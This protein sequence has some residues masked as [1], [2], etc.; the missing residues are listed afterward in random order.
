MSLLRRLADRPRHVPASRHAGG[1]ALAVMLV[2]AQAGCSL[3][4]EGVPP[5]ANRIFYPASAVVDPSG[6]WLFVASSNSDLRYN[7]G[8]LVAVDLTAAR[9]DRAASWQECPAAGYIRRAPGDPPCCLDFLDRTILNCDEQRYITDDMTVR[10]GSFAATMVW[11]DTCP[12]P[13]C[14]QGRLLIGVRGDGSITWIDADVRDGSDGSPP[15]V[16]LRCNDTVGHF[17]E[18]DSAHKVI[19]NDPDHDLPNPIRL[20]DEP[21]ALAVDSS[22]G[23]LYVGHLRGDAISIFD[24]ALN[25]TLATGPRFIAPF[26]NIF[27]LDGNGNAGVTSLNIHQLSG[28]PGELFA[29]SRYVPRVSAFAPTNA[30][31][32]PDPGAARNVA[33]LST[34]IGFDTT[35]V[36]SE[37]RGI[38]F[39]AGN[40]RAYALQRVPPALV[41][42]DVVDDPVRGIVTTATEV[43]EMCSSPTF[44]YQQDLT[45]TG[46]GGTRL[47]VNCFDDNRIYVVD[48]SVPRLIA[49]IDVGQGP[50]GLAFDKA[51]PNLAYV[52]GFGANDLSVLDLT[53]YRVVQRIGFPSKQPR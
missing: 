8:T 4:Q 48:A 34:G 43:L 20:P 45:A 50:A 11:Q 10:I 36:G 41:G 28:V 38:E 19:D 31:L 18:C 21:Y 46:G 15:R 26:S 44:L 24:V 30:A 12:A 33:L 1:V 6:S 25:A 9:A 16:D 49:T 2:G 35:L 37:I 27:P 5:P 40:Q 42:F 32:T 39:L 53:A 17:A 22:D 14:L 23:L 51:D 7:D 13:P 47:F 52:V 29:S 3:S